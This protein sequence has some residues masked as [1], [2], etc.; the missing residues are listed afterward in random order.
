MAYGRP[1]RAAILASLTAVAV[2]AACAASPPRPVA[3]GAEIRAAAGAAAPASPGGIAVTPETYIRAETDRNFSNIVKLAGG[4]NRFFHYRAP[5]PLDRQ[6]VVR[7]NKDT[8]YSGAVV[9]T[10]GGAWVTLPESDAGRYMSILVID[11][12]HY[13]PAVFYAPGRHALP[14]RTK[15]VMVVLRTQLLRPDDPADL[16]K[17]N[18]LQDRVLIETTRAEPFPPSKWEPASLKALTERYERDAAAFSSWKGM[19]GPPGQVDEGTRHIAAAAAWGLFPEAHATYLNY[20][21]GHPADVCHMATYAV[22]PNQAFWSI[23]VYGTDG[24]MKHQ[25]AILNSTNVKP[26]ADGTFT[27]RFGS[28]AA[29]GD[30]PNRLD[31]EQGWNFLMRVYRPGGAVLDGTYRLPSVVPVR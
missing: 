19:M 27:A 15:Y 31:V 6:A 30:V 23:T 28:R 25:N 20:N 29:C 13:A 7:M 16:A 5:L 4:T 1:R 2:L 12:D 17:V 21:G 22:P 9:D 14:T 3:D 8:L 10:E 11:N 18:A 26:N 24:Y